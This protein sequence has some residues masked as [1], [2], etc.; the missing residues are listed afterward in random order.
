MGLLYALNIDYTKGLKYTFEIIQ[1]DLMDIGWRPMLLIGS[2]LEKQTL[3]EE[4][5]SLTQC[6]KLLPIEPE[7]A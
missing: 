4:N 2:W 7:L 6:F 5:V 3:E 1:K